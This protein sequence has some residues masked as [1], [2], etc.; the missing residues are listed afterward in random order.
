[1][2]V[3]ITGC[4]KPENLGYKIAQSLLSKDGSIN[5]I[6]I[7]DRK[8]QM[9]INSISNVEYLCDLSDKTDIHQTCFDIRHKFEKIDIFIHA[10][11]A[12]YVEWFDNMDFIEFE[13]I[14]TINFESSLI[15]SKILLPS[16]ESANGTIFNVISSAANIPMRC[17]LA[18]NCSKAALQMATM[19]LARELSKRV[20]VLGINPNK[21][22]NTGMTAAND[23]EIPKIRGWSE[24]QYKIEENKN[25]LSGE[26]TDANVCADFIAEILHKKENHKHLTGSIIQYGV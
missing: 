15:I 9:D 7:N 4:A 5:I 8:N 6:T 18:Y 22:S 26:L 23:K 2:N 25:C 12:N 10:A 3:V 1:M 11:G 24:D 21:F 19:Q 17:S 16:I 20:S 13:R 14:M